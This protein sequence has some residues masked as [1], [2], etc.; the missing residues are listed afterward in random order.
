MR[1]AE[2]RLLRYGHF[3]DCSLSFPKGDCDLQIILGPNEA[4]KSTS[5]AAVS[6]LLFAFKPRTKFAFRFDQKLLRIGAVLESEGR[7][8][9]VCRRKGTGDTLSGPDDQT[10]SEA[11]LGAML[12]G[13]TRESFR[14]MFGL[15][16]AQLRAG[17]E[18]IMRAED[19][20]GAAIFSAGSG[21]VQVAKVCEELEVEAKAIWAKGAGESRR[22]T[23][24]LTAFQQARADLKAAEVRPA[25]WLRARKDL[26][27]AE[28]E[29]K[30]LSDRRALLLKE[31]RELQRKQRILGPAQR[32][33]AALA[34]L[35]ALHSVPRISAQDI[36]VCEDALVDRLAA[37]G[38]LATAT[39][40][41]ARLTEEQG[42]ATPDER[43]LDLA[44]EIDGLREAKGVVD[45]GRAEGPALAS[46]REQA[47][48]RV[49]AMAAELGWPASD[50]SA[51]QAALPAR[52]ALAVLRELI[53][54]RGSIEEQVR[55]ARAA[56]RQAE[57]DQSLL[58]EQLTAMPATADVGAIRDLVRD[59]REAGLVQALEHAS[60]TARE[61]ERTLSF[62]LR[63]LAPW[64][65]DVEALRA[66]NLPAEAD[67]EFAYDRLD[68][69]R[70]RVEVESQA[71]RR[72]AERV[73]D[74][75]L[76]LRHAALAHPAPTRETL[77]TMRQNRDQLWISLRAS[78]VEGAPIDMPA[79]A[80]EQFEGTI[81]SSD[82]I[83]DERF[84]AAEHTGELVARE[85]EIEKAEL[86]S[87]QASERLAG[88][89]SE[90]AGALKA[91]ED[92][93]RP[94]AIGLSPEAYPSW[95]DAYRAALEMADA[96]QT[97]EQ[98]EQRARQAHDQAIAA[99]L[100]A[101]GQAPNASPLPLSQ[102]LAQAE[103]VVSE[104]HD[105][106][107]RDEAL[108][109]QL[110]SASDGLAR[111]K[112][113]LDAAL[114]ADVRW[115][116][117][118][119]PALN[120]AGLDEH[121]SVAAI[122]A[123]LDLVDDLRGDLDTLLDVDG[124]L[125]VMRLVEEGF[126]A[127]VSVAAAQAGLTETDTAET[128]FAL[129]KASADAKA[130]L[131]RHTTLTQTLAAAQNASRLAQGRL[132]AANARLG[133]LSDEA[134]TQPLSVL[135]E[136]LDAARD[137]SR[138]R[139]Q[140]GELEAEIL[141]AGDGHSLD[142]LLAEAIGADAAEVATK[143]SAL[144]EELEALMGKIDSLREVR[145][146]A[147]IAFAALDDRPD[148][149]I[150]AARMA[151]ARSEM[152]YQA[153]LYI[154]KRAEVRLLRSAIERYRHEK[155]GP[156]LAR[157]SGLFTTL[158]L[159]RFSR[160]M[161]DY[162]ADKPTLAALRNDGESVVPVDGMS[163]GTLD[164]LYLALRI[165]AV[166]DAV[167]NGVR[168]PFLADDLFINFDDERA[169]AG[170][171]VLAELARSTQVLFF[172]H[173]EHLAQVADRALSPAKVSVCGLQRQDASPVLVA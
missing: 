136:R 13:Q 63:E 98:E 168:L 64:S 141:S 147:E 56:V 7:A 16:H 86:E 69:A 4:G 41:I 17:G 57:T 119:R 73:D 9:E 134:A 114:E 50:L 28:A 10:I 111:G 58:Q 96:V 138:L 155:Q 94:L 12:G 129:Q 66:L 101:M 131:A 5:L 158:T 140:I 59:V 173:H 81:R 70:E 25:A 40:E 132:L 120:A 36:Q 65:G 89:H 33:S 135:R 92:L 88:A 51:L 107:V 103:R 128:Y 162:E 99:L 159:G 79:Q 80:A 167:R 84:S 62:R 112:L 172:T 76:Q 26:D 30:V 90:W 109:A 91:F 61:L 45:Q 82:R 126:A 87:R 43:L 148:A 3:Q 127:R 48:A 106:R 160:L 144:Q 52:S 11:T 170:F 29:L 2:L 105:A 72:E 165:A 49:S 32:R 24:A 85:R 150:A 149:A 161:V 44:D 20:I 145:Q 118:W 166:E 6:D 78:L 22:Y 83:A 60:K 77:E 171:K 123:Q 74:L 27:A 108:K 100:N 95:R 47:W 154:R 42:A 163:E 153:E 97:A 38:D 169:A 46:R 156:L 157:A 146:A 133:A 23:A 121:S 1:F 67:V 54:R 71:S 93:V 37:E 124:R 115:Q 8:I 164:Q 130:K 142:L 122:R 18:E 15:D 14:R 137:A 104:A 19:D 110:R 152:A 53:E 151:E 102:L 68:R 116:A 39:S 21:I 31:Q 139:S 117:E 125:D 143:V 35:E 75:R 113:Q 34:K 55:G